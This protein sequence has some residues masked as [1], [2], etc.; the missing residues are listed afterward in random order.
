MVA[1]VEDGNLYVPYVP[2]L[3]H[4]NLQTL[5]ALKIS[6]NEVLIPVSLSNR[7][8]EIALKECVHLRF[9]DLTAT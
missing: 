9:L 8:L 4:P 3:P 5:T 1:I 6:C 7:L 2:S